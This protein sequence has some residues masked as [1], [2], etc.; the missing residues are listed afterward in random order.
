VAE[1]VRFKGEIVFDGSKADGP[2]QKTCSNSR[3]RQIKLD[4]KF[5]PTGAA[6]KVKATGSSEIMLTLMAN[7][8]T[9][10][11]ILRTQ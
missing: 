3:L 5:T 10:D 8:L 4:C 11:L 1:A 9:S 2:L 7:V 6:I